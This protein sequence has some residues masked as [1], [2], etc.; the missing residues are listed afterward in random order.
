MAVHCCVD[1][2]KIPQPVN[3]T[4]ELD[5]ILPLD[6]PV[7]LVYFQRILYEIL[8]MA[9]HANSSP[10]FIICLLLQNKESL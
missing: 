1:K 3:Y 6:W 2:S 7:Q 4:G 9:K 8:C 10:L 5:Y